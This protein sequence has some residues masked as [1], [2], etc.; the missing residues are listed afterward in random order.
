ML[1]QGVVYGFPSSMLRALIGTYRGETPSS[2]AG[3][4]SSTYGGVYLAEP[5]TD[6]QLQACANVLAAPAPAPAPEPTPA[7][8]TTA[9]PVSLNRQIAALAH[10]YPVEDHPLARL[11]CIA[12]IA[13]TDD[14]EWLAIR[15]YVHE[16]ITGDVAQQLKSMAASI[17]KLQQQLSSEQAARVEATSN[18]NAALAKIAAAQAA[19]K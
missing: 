5:M 6:Q 7:P 11:A 12:A 9:D 3:L 16:A 1:S 15:T 2:Y 8:S 10:E 17:D 18:L 19:L 14:S 13:E 4:S